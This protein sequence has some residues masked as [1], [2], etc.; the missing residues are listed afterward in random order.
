[1]TSRSVVLLLAL[2][3]AAF[4]I[5][6]LQAAPI[7]DQSC[8]PELWGTYSI[9]FGGPMGQEFVPSVEELW[10]VD[11]FVINNPSSLDDTAQVYVV[12]HADSVQTPDLGASE[13]EWIPKPYEGVI[14][15]TFNE[16]VVM[17]PGR[18]YVIEARRAAGPGNPVLLWGNQLGSCD[19]VSGI[20]QGK[21]FADGGDFWYRTWYQSIPV[22]SVTWGRVKGAAGAGRR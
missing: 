20:W 11:L 12:I 19:G 2:A 18:T 3:C 22:E 1:M 6:S 4:P 10:Q 8:E 15:F 5:A 13:P 9:A 7:L 17:T 21:R 14:T 16:P